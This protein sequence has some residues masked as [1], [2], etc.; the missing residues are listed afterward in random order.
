[1]TSSPQR[2]AWM[3][4]LPMVAMLASLTLT[5]GCTQPD[6]RASQSRSHYHPPAC[7]TEDFPDIPVLLVLSGYEF[8]PDQDQLAISLAGGTVRRFEISLVRRA[9]E[10]QDD[11]PS[12]VLQRLDTELSGLGWIAETAGTWHEA[13][14]RLIIEAGRSGRLTTVRF[15]LRPAETDDSRS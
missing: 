12:A 14:E 8:D 4:A 2:A 7:N 11:P 9:R 3:R 6:T 10:Q 1:M 13:G 5:A 15:H